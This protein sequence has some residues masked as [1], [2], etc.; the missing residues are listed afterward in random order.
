MDNH[1]E[2]P[3][4]LLEGYLDRSLTEAE[5]G[6]FEGELERRADLRAAI[7]QQQTIDESL[8][9]LARPPAADRLRSIVEPTVSNSSRR[10]SWGG[11]RVGWRKVALAA[12]LAGAV[13]G[14]W[15]IWQFAASGPAGPPYI[16]QPWRSL[17]TVYRETTSGGFEPNWVCKDDREFAE[18]FRA[19]YGQALLLHDLPEGT[20]A[21]GLSYCHNMT[22]RTTCVLATAADRALM[23]FVDRIE[24]DF[25]QPPPGHLNLFRREIGRLVLY[26]VSPLDAPVML[27][28]FY[29]PEKQA[30]RE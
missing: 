2:Q 24:R 30:T 17:E 23:V 9:R 3:E 21:L 18:S 14:G 22:P 25:S 7:R 20:A 29:D 27:D 13:Y 26:E 16:T 1:A 5:C 10:V 4:M 28:A 15:S 12:A 19:V 11:R 8:N 6:A